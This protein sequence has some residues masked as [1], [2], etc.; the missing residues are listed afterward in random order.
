VEGQRSLASETAAAGFLPNNEL[1][2]ARVR[3]ALATSV[4]NP[5][6][7]DVTVTQGIVTLSGPVLAAEIDRMLDAVE[8]VPGVTRAEC[9]VEPQAEADGLIGLSSLPH[10]REGRY[11]WNLWAIAAAFAAVGVAGFALIRAARAR[12]S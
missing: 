1:L 9:R 4:S 8:Q 5:G 7:V 10:S 6:A 12:R 11:G 3:A 2:A